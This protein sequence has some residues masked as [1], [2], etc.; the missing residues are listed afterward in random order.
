MVE[1][2]RSGELL[3]KSKGHLVGLAG[4][5]HKKEDSIEERGGGRTL[6]GNQS[7]GG[8]GGAAFIL[9]NLGFKIFLQKWQDAGDGLE[10]ERRQNSSG[11]SN[12]NNTEQQLRGFINY[13]PSLGQYQLIYGFH[14]VKRK[15]EKSF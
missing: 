6:A 8:G 2:G 4:F 1:S 13:N 5:E 9:L 12:S 15:E 7:G 14:K 11:Y 3:A 10:E